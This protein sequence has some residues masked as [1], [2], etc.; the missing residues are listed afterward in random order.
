MVGDAAVTL[1]ISGENFTPSS[2]VLWNGV[3]KQTKF[4]RSDRIETSIDRIDLASLDIAKVSVRNADKIES[5]HLPFFIKT[6]TPKFVY[7]LSVDDD[8]TYFYS[9][10]FYVF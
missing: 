6:S 2:A 5:N 7:A 9:I 8:G 10:S 4:I 3:E 1:Q